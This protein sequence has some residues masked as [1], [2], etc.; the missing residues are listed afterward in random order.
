[1]G[2][3]AVSELGIYERD[4]FVLNTCKSLGIPVATVIGGGYDDNRAALAARHAL[5]IKAAVAVFAEQN[6]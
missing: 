4:F 2:H 1:M 5:V 3:F 6:C